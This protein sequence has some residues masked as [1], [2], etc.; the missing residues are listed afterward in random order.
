ML[1][2][3]VLTKKSVYVCTDC[4]HHCEKLITKNTNSNVNSVIDMLINDTID[5]EDCVRL[6]EALG[7]HLNL[8]LI[9]D[10]KLNSKLYKDPGYLGVYD[11]SKWIKEQDPT[12]TTL[13]ESIIQDK[14]PNPVYFARLYEQVY[15]LL[16]KN[17]IMPLSFSCS[18]VT[19]LVTGSR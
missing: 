8:K 16:A 2:L 3:E 15:Q 1:S 5:G 14:N 17:N 9:K 4:A 11:P 7:K 19:Y 6:C 18:L 10:I 13:I 12:F